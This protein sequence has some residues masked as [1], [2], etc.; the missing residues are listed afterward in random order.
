[1]HIG[2][3]NKYNMKMKIAIVVLFMVAMYIVAFSPKAYEPVLR[4]T[5]STTNATPTTLYSWSI[6]SGQT[7]R[8]V[9]DLLAKSG[10]N[11]L[12]GIKSAT[13]KNISG[14]LTVV[15][16][17]VSDLAAIVADPALVSAGWT[18][19]TSGTNVIIQVT[20]IAATNIDWVS[21]TYLYMD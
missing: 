20:G 11:R 12:R 17:T 8:L 4:S 10:N 2:M 19:T 9:V 15:G 13:V 16:A 5:V 14:T 7:V 3:W 21:N 1:M 6:A 18:I